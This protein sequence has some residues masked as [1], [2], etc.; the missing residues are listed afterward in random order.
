[1]KI[2]HNSPIHHDNHMHNQDYRS[3]HFVKSKN[4]LRIFAYVLIGASSIPK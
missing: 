3:I 2:E 1:M 4:S